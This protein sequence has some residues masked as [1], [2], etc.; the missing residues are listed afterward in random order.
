[1][2][3]SFSIIIPCY[4]AGVLISEAL[5][6][7][8]N[9]NYSNE[10]MELI[11]INDAST[12]DSEK[13]IK[14]FLLKTKLNVIFLQNE[15]NK[16]LGFSRNRGIEMAS[17]NYVVFLDADDQLYPNSLKAINSVIT[18]KQDLIFLNSNQLEVNNTIVQFKNS[19]KKKVNEILLSPKDFRIGAVFYCYNINFLFKSKLLFKDIIHEDILFCNEVLIKL[20]TFSYCTLP[21]YFRIVRKN[22]LS[23]TNKKKR[24]YDLI[25]IS[26]S[27][28]N[29]SK[30]LSYEYRLFLRYFSRI[31][32]TSAF[33]AIGSTGNFT[34]IKIFLSLNINYILENQDL[35]FKSKLLKFKIFKS[36]IFIPIYSLILKLNYR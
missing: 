21:T 5:N 9:I 13:Y 25:K 3:E 12:D 11:I 30:K 32:L 27:L 2:A 16:G 8:Q 4:N 29:K 15:K 35:L 14:E 6:S 10:L 22:S 17:K 33:N 18:N 23:T 31:S 26:K 20:K 24:A 1:M 34:E 7:C 36:K 28:L 19:I